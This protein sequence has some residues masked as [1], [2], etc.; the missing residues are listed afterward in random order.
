MGWEVSLVSELQ[1]MQNLTK[2]NVTGE[3]NLEKRKKK[4]N[5]TLSV[6]REEQDWDTSKLTSAVVSKQVPNVNAW[7]GVYILYTYLLWSFRLN[8]VH[9]RLL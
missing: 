8:L 3:F 4:N 5:F 1:L 9:E 2:Q 6:L 7:N